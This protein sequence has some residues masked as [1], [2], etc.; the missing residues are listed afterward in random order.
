MTPEA[1]RG[2][3]TTL[4]EM[5]FAGAGK[6]AQEMATD[7][8][9]PLGSFARVL[10]WAEHPDRRKAEFVLKLLG[11]L[12]ILPWLA[13]SRKLSGAP[14]IE[15]LSEAYRIY[16]DL[17]RR[18]VEK[19]RG[20]LKGQ[21]LLPPPQVPGAVEARIPVTREGDEAYLLLRH[22]HK[23]DEAEADDRRMRL[24][25]ARLCEEDRNR[26]IQHYLSTGEFQ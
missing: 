20:M 9:E 23:P 5:D 8:R 7:A 25:F 21:T 16:H 10:E 13:A 14:R 3:L 22:L 15:A 1:I 12:S 4:R 24:T 17:D 2:R 18:V 6:L 26:M 19:L 11:E